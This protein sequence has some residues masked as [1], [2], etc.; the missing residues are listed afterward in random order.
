MLFNDKN[1]VKKKLNTLVNT[2]MNL[3]KSTDV[4]SFDTAVT[5]CLPRASQVGIWMVNVVTS[6]SVAVQ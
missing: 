1:M 6:L 4:R 3:L 5:A 2:L